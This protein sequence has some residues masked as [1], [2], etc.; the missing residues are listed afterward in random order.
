MCRGRI[1]NPSPLTE[2][3]MEATKS[4]ATHAR[5]NSVEG[6]VPTRKTRRLSL[7]TSHRATKTA[8]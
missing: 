1:A 8:Q 3:T 5:Q 7:T 4:N 6:K 2:P